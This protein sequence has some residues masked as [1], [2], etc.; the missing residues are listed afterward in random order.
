MTPARSPYIA[1][2]LLAL[3]VYA[4]GLFAFERGSRAVHLWTDLFWTVAAAYATW[5]CF[6][7]AHR[8]EG[9]RRRAWMLF[10]WGCSS[11]LAGILV[12]DYRELV[13]HEYQPFA[14]F[15]D[16]ACLA[17]LVFFIVGFFYCRAET[18]Y[19]RAALRKLCNL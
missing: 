13:L 8:L 5:E 19:A 16:Y 4:G 9:A 15:Q 10:G 14:G 11:W 17:L 6:R 2:L 12:W 3:L 18:P 7:T 1:A